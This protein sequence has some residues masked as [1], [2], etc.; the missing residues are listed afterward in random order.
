MKRRLLWIFGTLLLVGA[1]AVF[2]LYQ[3][4]IVGGSVPSNLPEEQQIV[5]VPTG[6]SFDQ[7]V[8]TLVAQGI[9]TDV[10]LFQKLSDRMEYQRDPMRSGRFE[11]KPGY[12]HARTDSPSAQWQTGSH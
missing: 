6:A 2:Y 5:Y 1:I 8:D 9:V 12:A 3:R 11:V 4:F 10:P 7:V